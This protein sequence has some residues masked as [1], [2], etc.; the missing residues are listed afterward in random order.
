MADKKALSL[1]KIFKN[2]I[3][4]YVQRITDITHLASLEARL[5]IKTLITISILCLVIV[6]FAIS[7]WLNLLLVFYLYLVSLH[8]SFLA[9]AIFILGLNFVAI[10]VTYLVIRKIKKNLF[11][12]ATRRATRRQFSALKNKG[13]D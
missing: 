4:A 3:Q 5:A 7:F 1:I 13:R 12:P 2:L 11:F 10:L 9:S 6:L 8:Y